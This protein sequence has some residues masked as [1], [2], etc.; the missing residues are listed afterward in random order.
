MSRWT[1]EEGA[2]LPLGVSWVES[3]R[4]YNFALYSKHA[5]R[6]TLLVYGKDPARPFFTKPLD[7]RIHKS[8]RIWHCRVPEETVEGARYYAYSVDG[9]APKDRFE[10][11]NFDPQK[12]LLDPYAKAV[13]F[14]PAFDPLA[15]IRSDTTGARRLSG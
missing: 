12:V 1:T 5:E 2:S 7:Y 9:P 4:A 6:V 15:A 8:G 14:P 10:W 3:E 13:Y 11:H